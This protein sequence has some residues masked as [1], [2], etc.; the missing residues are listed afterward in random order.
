M[1]S[2]SDCKVEQHGISAPATDVRNDCVYVC[3]VSLHVHAYAQDN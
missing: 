2:R 3:V 1:T